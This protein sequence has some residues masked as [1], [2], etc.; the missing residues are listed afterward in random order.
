M[1]RLYLTDK[2][3]ELTREALA[4]EVAMVEHSMSTTTVE[5]CNHIGEVMQR[6]ISRI[7]SF[8]P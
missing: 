3:R 6:M 5:E 8:E 2:G 7:E 4:I 1:L